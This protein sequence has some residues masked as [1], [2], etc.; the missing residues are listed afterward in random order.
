MLYRLGLA[1]AEVANV[2]RASR[3]QCDEPTLY[4]SETMKSVPSPVSPARMP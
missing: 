4:R 3:A 2:A 1:K